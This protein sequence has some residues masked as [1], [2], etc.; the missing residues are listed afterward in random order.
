MIKKF[1]VELEGQIEF[2][3]QYLK[4]VNPKLTYEDIFRNNTDGILNGNLLEFKLV[5][6]DLNACLFQAIA[7][8]A[9]ALK[10]YFF[11]FSA[12]FL[13]NLQPQ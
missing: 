1:N 5:I 13:E 10:Y 3:E 9:N 6:T 4:V 7:S 8:A 12:T 11:R 2:Y